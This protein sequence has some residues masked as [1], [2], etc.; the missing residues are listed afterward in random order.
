M[1]FADYDLEAQKGGKPTHPNQPSNELDSIVANTSSQLQQF[2]QLINQFNN[3]RKLIGSKRDS[4]ESR[5]QTDALQ[6][7][8]SDLDSAI[9]SLIMNI[10]KAMNSE[11]TLDVTERQSMA[12]DRLSTEYH[13]LHLTFVSSRRVYN[14]R[15]SSVPLK[16]TAEVNERTPLVGDNSSQQQQQQQLTADEIEQSELQYHILLTEERNREINRVSEGIQEV[17]SIFKDLGALVNQQGE[18]LDT[19]EENVSELQGNTQQASRE[20]HKA[21]EYQKRR[22]KW[23]CILL[24]ALLIVVLVVVLAV[25]S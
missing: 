16:S 8:I 10:N 21:H 13:H 11:S 2:G 17:N 12:K 25:M 5:N 1:S 6:S 14:E 24:V 4:L 15:K 7:R 9:H 18:Q 3:Q 20:L 19:I 23:S 22:S